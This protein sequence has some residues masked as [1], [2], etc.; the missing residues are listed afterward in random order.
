MRQDVTV[1]HARVAVLNSS[2]DCDLSCHALEMKNFTFCLN[3][4]NSIP[5]CRKGVASG[6]PSEKYLSTKKSKFGICS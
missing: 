1:A 2:S 4:F 3:E 5:E 6:Y